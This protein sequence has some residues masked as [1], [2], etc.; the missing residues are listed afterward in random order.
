[1]EG[2][3]NIGTVFDIQSLSFHDGPGIRTL[4]FLKGC[5]LKCLW[6]AN[7]EGQGK[8]A[9]IRYH[10][11]NCTGCM[12]CSKTCVKNAIYMKDNS[13][14]IHREKCSNCEDLKCIDACNNDALKLSGKEMSVDEVMKIVKRDIPYYRGKGGVTLSGG[15]P[16]FQPQFAVSLLK[17]CK[18]EYVNTAIESAMFT[19]FDVVQ[20]FI[21]VTDLFLTDIKHMNS[22]KHINLTGVDNKQI[23]DNITKIAQLKPIVVRVPVIPGLND[24]D[25][26]IIDT[27]KFCAE[28]NI[29]RI[30]LLPYHQLGLPKYN[31]LELDY[32]MP[33]VQSPD[34]EK[35]NY[36]KELVES[37]DVKCI[38]G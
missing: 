32:N 30:N 19:N 35:M 4:I 9:E 28:N 16:T 17:A 33:K 3:N 10:S 1:M 29:S 36:L 34:N 23:L 15:D 2:K 25:E 13:I 26:N 7:P 24:D 22:A 31:Q 18:E 21:P 38:I 12:E 11:I 6:C 37:I 14:G 27:A 5:P 20:S 8:T